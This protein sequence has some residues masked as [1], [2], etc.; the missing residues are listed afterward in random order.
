MDYCA[1]IVDAVDRCSR[2]P[3]ALESG[4]I[5]KFNQRTLRSTHKPK[6]KPTDSHMPVEPVELA[7][8]WPSLLGNI[9]A[10]LRYSGNP[11]SENP[12]RIK[13]I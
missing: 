1:E 6:P 7:N 2:L 10:R 8:Q 4:I 11:C 9:E 5:A 3:G 13:N 12:N